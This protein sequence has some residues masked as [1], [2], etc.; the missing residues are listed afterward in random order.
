MFLGQ[1]KITQIVYFNVIVIIE[2]YPLEIRHKQDWG[3]GFIFLLAQAAALPESDA[4]SGVT[5]L[6]SSFVI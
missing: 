3:R 5:K 6:A 1:K 2:G 4:D